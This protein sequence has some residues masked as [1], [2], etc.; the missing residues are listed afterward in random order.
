MLSN[1]IHPFTSNSSPEEVKASALLLYDDSAQHTDENRE[2]FGKLRK[3]RAALYKVDRDKEMLVDV[4]IHNFLKSCSYLSP[5]SIEVDYINY[6]VK[7]QLVGD[8][9]LYFGLIKFMS[10][11]VRANYDRHSHRGIVS[12]KYLLG[13]LGV[14]NN[15]SD[16]SK[17][18]LLRERPEA[19]YVMYGLNAIS[20]ADLA[21]ICIQPDRCGRKGLVR[22]QVIP[23]EWWGKHE[24]MNRLSDV[25]VYDCYRASV[26][27]HMTLQDMLKNYT[28]MGRLSEGSKEKLRYARQKQ[29]DYEEAESA[30]VRKNGSMT[31]DN[32]PCCGDS[33]PSTVQDPLGGIMIDG[34]FV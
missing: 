11:D 31:Q 20:D 4:N 26:N 23:Y 27:I 21:E 12:D 14:F 9:A 24:I 2:K 1:A 17:K 3:E 33:L 7:E 16:C 19:M 13:D 29:R 25:V 18:A 5:N 6:L 22:R 32:Y 8:M 34:K 15:L 10:D 30:W 28:F